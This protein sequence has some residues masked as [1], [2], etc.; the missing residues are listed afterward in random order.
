MIGTPILEYVFLSLPE[1]ALIFVPD[2]YLN[3]ILRASWIPSL[4]RVFQSESVKRYH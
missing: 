4:F 1:A 3:E 2:E